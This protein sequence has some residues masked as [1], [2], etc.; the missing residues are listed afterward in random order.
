MYKDIGKLLKQQGFMKL[1]SKKEGKT[2][3]MSTILIVF[4]P[5]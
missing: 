4:L 2:R 1:K 5:L 3:E